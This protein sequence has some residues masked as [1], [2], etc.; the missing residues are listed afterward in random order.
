M[1]AQELRTAWLNFFAERGHK[2]Y[3]SSGLI[4]HHP[5][6]PLF[7]NAGMNQFLPYIVG[8]EPPPDPARATSVQKTVRVKGKHDDIEEIG[9]SPWHLSFFEMLGNFSLGDYFKEQAIKYAWELSTEVFRYDPE[10]IWVT[11]YETDDEA[12]AIWR[13]VVGVPAERVQRMG[14]DNFWEMGDTGPC[15]P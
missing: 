6:A 1:R 4:P 14:A 2:I 9:R 12:E 10:R 3:P 13:D 11:V 5:R 8:E 7:T 15:G